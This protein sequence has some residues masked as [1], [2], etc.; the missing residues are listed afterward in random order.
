VF[1]KLGFT[2]EPFGGTSI[3]VRGYPQ[4]IK[5]WSDGRLL[6]QIFDDIIADRAPGNS[7][8]EKLI[9]SY[10]CRSAIKQGSAHR[11]RDEAP[12]P[13]N[14]RGRPSVF[15]SARPS[16]IRA[17]RRSRRARIPALKRRVRSIRRPRS[18]NA[19]SMHAIMGTTAVGRR[20]SPSDRRDIRRRVVSIVRARCTA[21][22][23]WAREAP[24]ANARVRTT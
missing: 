7:L 8:N 5:N 22:S 4:G 20:N 6:L 21:A 11:R 18:M 14:F 13:I 2:L 17:P 1:Q 3:L 15:L 24:P 12:H 16:T 9:A 19:S 10:A 23:T